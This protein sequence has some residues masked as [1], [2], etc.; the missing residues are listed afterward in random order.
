M[1]IAANIIEAIRLLV[2]SIHGDSSQT[3]FLDREAALPLS[4]CSLGRRAIDR[5]DD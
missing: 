4:P 2:L 1:I 3:G 5:I